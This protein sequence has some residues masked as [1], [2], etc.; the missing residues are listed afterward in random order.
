[1]GRKRWDIAFEGCFT[2]L[3]WTIESITFVFIPL[4]VYFIAFS[5]LGIKASNLV[6]LPEWLFISVVLF[7][8]S[9]K[10]LVVSR[11]VNQNRVRLK[12][13]IAFTVILGIFGLIVSSIFLLISVLNQ[14]GDNYQL[15]TD[16]H[17]WQMRI[18]ATAIGYS[19]TIRIFRYMD[20]VGI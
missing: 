8:T 13:T 4:L 6:E 12:Y 19:L 20:R 9:L 18:V 5:L 14:Y 2:L 7:G 16:F 1:M 17:K 15:P 11:E 3:L 10:E